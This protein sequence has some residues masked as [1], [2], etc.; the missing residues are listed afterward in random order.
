M[1]EALPFEG[2]EWQADPGT[3]LAVVH[4]VTAAKEFCWLLESEAALPQRDFIQQL[5][6]TVLALYEAA[7]PLP[8]VDPELDSREEPFFDQNSRQTLRKQLAERLGGDVADP[9]S[10]DL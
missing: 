9:E 7:L 4:F 3:G 8:D 6:T 2:H 1:T 10:H 5:L